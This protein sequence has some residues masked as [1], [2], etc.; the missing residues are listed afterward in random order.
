MVDLTRIALISYAFGTVIGF[1]GRDQ[2]RTLSKGSSE[3][4]R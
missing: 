4:R 1:L 3:V 2:N